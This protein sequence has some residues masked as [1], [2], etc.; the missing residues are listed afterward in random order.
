MELIILIALFC[1]WLIENPAYHY[2]LNKLKLDVKPFNCLY[3]LS[4]WIALIAIYTT[5]KESIVIMF[6]QPSAASFLA[7]MISRLTASQ[8]VRIK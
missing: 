2:V 8:P 3:C 7:V 4:F 5:G 6:F 1:N